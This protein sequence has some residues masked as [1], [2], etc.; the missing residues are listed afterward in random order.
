MSTSIQQPAPVTP[1]RPVLVRRDA[2]DQTHV[3]LAPS[4]EERGV[5]RLVRA[6]AGGDEAA[7]QE[8]VRRYSGLVNGVARAHRLSAADT[9]DVAQATWARL[10]E[11]LPRLHRPAAVGAWLA[12][13]ARRESLHTLRRAARECPSDDLP[14]RPAT[15][16]GANLDHELLRS[17]RDAALWRAFSRLPERAQRLLRALSDEEEPSY[18]EIGTALQMPIGSIGPTRA[19]SLTRL[20]RELEDT[21]GLEALAA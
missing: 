4:P 9:A 12:T 13:T 17:E 8:L 18:A 3:R 15:P 6:A 10:V 11:H 21:G 16:D 1:I 7:W 20:R 14:D 5:E 19:R 2:D